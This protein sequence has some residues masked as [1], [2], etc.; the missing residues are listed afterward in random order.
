MV[1]LALAG[2]L[3]SFYTGVENILKRIVLRAQRLRACLGL[4]SLLKMSR[5]FRGH[6]AIPPLAGFRNMS[7]P[8]RCLF[9]RAV[10]HVFRSA[11]TFDLSWDKRVP[12]PRECSRAMQAIEADV[13]S[14]L[15]SRPLAP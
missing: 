6:V 1:T 2:F 3:R 11:C 15:A 5:L 4:S 9:Q 14:F 7:P 12:L 13:R 10:R 8:T